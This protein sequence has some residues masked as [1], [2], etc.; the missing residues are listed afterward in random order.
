MART[1]KSE[2]RASVASE[3]SLDYTYLYRYVNNQLQAP[4]EEIKREQL[5]NPYWEA[6]D[7]RVKTESS[8]AKASSSSD[9]LQSSSA[10]NGKGWRN[11]AGP[12]KRHKAP[13][14]VQIKGPEFKSLTIDAHNFPYK[15]RCSQVDSDEAD[16]QGCD[17]H[18]EETP[19]LWS[20]GDRPELRDCG[21]ERSLVHGLQ[22]SAHHA[23][24]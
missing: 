17:R 22:S 3:S 13:Q 9:T 21:Q 15:Q 14:E 12:P 10:R 6:Q 18:R 5:V 2:S 1:R 7:G 4:I 24:Q 8:A 11:A 19:G 16:R 23:A 20:E